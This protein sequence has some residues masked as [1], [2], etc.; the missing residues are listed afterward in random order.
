MLR[1]VPTSEDDRGT[2]RRR[3][4][5]LLAVAVLFTLLDAIKPLH[6]DDTYYFFHARQV[7]AAPLDPHGFLIFW[8]ERPEPA[9]NRVA[10]P[11]L[12]YWLAPAVSAFPDTP[13]VWKMW[14]LPF[15]FALVIA[16]DALFRRF[17]P[18]LERPLLLLTLASPA[19]LPS[20]NMMLDVPALALALTAQVLFMRASDALEDARHPAESRAAASGL[21]AAGAG[22]CAGLAA[23]TKYTALVVPVVWLAWAV[24]HRHLRLWVLATSVAAAVFG[25]WEGFTALSYGQSHFLRH[26]LRRAEPLSDRIPLPLALPSVL[27]GAAPGLALL[28]LT[29]RGAPASLLGRVAAALAFV[30]AVLIAINP[31]PL[32]VTFATGLFAAVGLV[33]LVLLLAATGRLLHE[34]AAGA[35]TGRFLVAW[36]AIEAAGYVA[37]SPFPAVRRVLPLA[38]VATLVLGHLAASSLDTRRRAAVWRAAWLSAAVGSLVAAVDLVEA[39][40]AERAAT[41]C[42]DWIRTHDPSARA[43][44]GGHWGFQY[45][46]ERAGLRPVVSGEFRSKTM[47]HAGDWLVIPSGRID[48]QQVH[49]DPARLEPAHEVRVADPLPLATTPHFYAGLVP[50]EWLDGP[51]A[52]AVVY[53]VTGDF[54]P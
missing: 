31:W 27:G 39:R 46:A 8:H 5:A 24:L 51:R 45:Y 3:L 25:A 20:L 47:L 32:T 43:F 38:V 17:A 33:L 22:L 36:L 42:A 2:G 30:L 14:L 53:R 26:V 12:P 29:T 49:L 23:Q 21:W 37:L 1:A 50:L 34:P 52:A 28:A 11:V 41:A 18:G 6:V 48:Q 13:W 16:L 40:A 7:A 19:L 4:P 35:R 9:G 54:Q 15:A 44:F 10:P